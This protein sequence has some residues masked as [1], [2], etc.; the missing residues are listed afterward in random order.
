MTVTL[1][2][3]ALRKLWEQA[4]RIGFTHVPERGFWDELDPDGVHLVCF[5]F[6]HIPAMLRFLEPEEL[7]QPAFACF[8][9]DGGRNIRARLMLKVRGSKE[10][11]LALCDFDRVAFG[12]A[13]RVVEDDGSVPEGQHRAQGGA[14]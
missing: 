1:T 4:E 9:H 7:N 3:P 8:K 5:W 13:V 12:R 11:V 10:P 14:A 6:E 2:T